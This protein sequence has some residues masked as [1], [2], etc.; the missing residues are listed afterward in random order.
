MSHQGVDPAR[1]AE[2]LSRIRATVVVL[3]GKG[4]VGKSTV[5]V[6]IAAGMAARGR[7]VGLLDADL[8]GPSVPGMLGLGQYA[9][10]GD[11]TALEPA[12]ACEGRLKVMSIQFLLRGQHDSVI[13]RGPL[14]HAVIAQFLGNTVWG[15]LDLLIVDSPPGTGDEPLSVVQTAHPAGAI[16]VTT[17]QEVATSDVRRSI[18][19]CRHLNLPVI[20]VIE[21]MSGFVCPHCGAATAI[22]GSG[23][24]REM[25][26]SMDVPFLGALP[27]DPAMVALGD[28]G[29][30]CFDDGVVCGLRAAYEGIVE[31]VAAAVGGDG[32]GAQAG[33]STPQ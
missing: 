9:A 33:R 5:A 31:T 18:D 2:T 30:T 8:H 10:R 14:K 4:G 28:A 1:L 17:P 12:L 26:R 16:V 19:F 23:G 13:W 29:R 25:A 24:G 27:I 11:E 32:S 21:N 15:D 7:R 20:G 22:F 3:S 6:N